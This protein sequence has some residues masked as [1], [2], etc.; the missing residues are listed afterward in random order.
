MPGLTVTEIFL[1]RAKR[2]QHL[3]ERDG[4]SGC[5]GDPLAA[6]CRHICNVLRR[7]FI[8][9]NHFPALRSGKALS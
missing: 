6:A 4:I 5:G 7:S 9:N 1:R 8:A 3:E 2:L